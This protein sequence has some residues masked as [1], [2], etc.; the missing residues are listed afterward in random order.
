MK[1]TSPFA[2][3]HVVMDYCDHRLHQVVEGGEA[4][5]AES[6]PVRVGRRRGTT[7]LPFGRQR[8]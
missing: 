4:Q 5:E 6:C 8:A 2:L 7:A 1:P 3:G